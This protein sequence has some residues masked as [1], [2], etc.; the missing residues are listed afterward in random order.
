MMQKDEMAVSAAIAG[1]ITAAG[2]AAETYLRHIGGAPGYEGLG[3]ETLSISVHTVCQRGH[4]ELRAAQMDFAGSIDAAADLVVK[5]WAS[6]EALA[7]AL[8][9]AETMTFAECFEVADE[10]GLYDR[11]ADD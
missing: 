3:S 11:L 4:T 2:P 8:L 6:V 1:T 9:K 10:S 5:H 7:T